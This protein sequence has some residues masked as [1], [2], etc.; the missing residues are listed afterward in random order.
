MSQGANYFFGFLITFVVLL[1]IFVACGIGSRRFFYSRRTLFVNDVTDRSTQTTQPTFWEAWLKEG[2]PN[3]NN[4][5]VSTNWIK[6]KTSLPILFSVQPLSASLVRRKDEDLE[7]P[8]P[9]QLHNPFATFFTKP[10]R[11]TDAP[12]PV[13]EEPPDDLQL[14]VMISMPS[15]HDHEQQERR[16]MEYEIGVT[17]V[18]WRDKLES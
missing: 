17:R 7:A 11:Q 1:L 4:M 10:S 8:P 5:A 16:P 13:D 15:S 12:Q 18:P 9:P 3:W 6:K 14:A 2:G